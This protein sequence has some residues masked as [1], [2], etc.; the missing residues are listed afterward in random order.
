MYMPS[1]KI[2]QEPKLFFNAIWEMHKSRKYYTYFKQRFSIKDVGF[3][4]LAKMWVKLYN[5]TSWKA[6]SKYTK[7]PRTNQDWSNPSIA[8]LS[9]FLNINTE[10]VERGFSHHPNTLRTS[11]LKFLQATC[12]IWNCLADL[13]F[14]QLWWLLIRKWVTQKHVPGPEHFSVLF[15]ASCKLKHTPVIFLLLQVTFT[16]LS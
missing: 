4:S 1:W 2:D 15:T 14:L 13:G 7:L 9:L 6:A 10:P 3:F 16:T 11:T 5:V 12:E 8:F